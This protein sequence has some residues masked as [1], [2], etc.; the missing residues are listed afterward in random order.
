MGESVEDRGHREHGQGELRV[1]ED[2]RERR[3]LAAK[4]L[5]IDRRREHDHRRD[6]RRIQ[7]GDGELQREAQAEGEGHPPW[8]R[9]E[10][11]ERDRP[12]PHQDLPVEEPERR[13]PDLIGEV[14]ERGPPPG[15][16]TPA[17]RSAAPDERRRGR[18]AYPRSPIDHLRFVAP[19][20]AGPAR[21]RGGLEEDLA[22]P[23]ETSRLPSLSAQVLRA[24]KTGRA[25]PYGL[26]V[27]R[28]NRSWVRSSPSVI[29]A[30]TASAA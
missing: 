10:M 25:R 4:L 6:G 28:L 11:H 5:L 23:Q 12:G 3:M 8:E 16:R 27:E 18:T 15:A 20:D 19:M 29:S 22:S 13:V 9:H 1:S 17:R 14:S 30:R 26:G 21:R 7:Q 2:D 24:L